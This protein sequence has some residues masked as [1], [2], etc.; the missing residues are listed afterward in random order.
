MI[1]FKDYL[2]NES[3]AILGQQIGDVL[4]AIHD[5]IENREGLGNRQVIRDSEGIVNQIR[6]ILHSHWDKKDQRHLEDLQKAGVAIAKA[7]EE[8]GDLDAVIQSSSQHLEKMLSDMGVP[9][10][11]LATTGTPQAAPT[12]LGDPQG[13]QQPQQQ[14]PPQQ[15]QQPPPQQQQQPPAP[16]GEMPPPMPGGEMPPDMGMPTPGPPTPPMAQ[17]PSLA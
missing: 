2:L 8:K 15:Q 5:M 3:T 1:R 14:Q 12:P 17:P 11:K 9:I 10:N 16:G 7:I 13:E 6:R 4:N